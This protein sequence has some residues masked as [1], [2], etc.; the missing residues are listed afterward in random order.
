[1]IIGWLCG[2][3]NLISFANSHITDHIHQVPENTAFFWYCVTGVVVMMMGHVCH[4]YLQ[5]TQAPL[6]EFMG[7][8]ITLTGLVL[9]IFMPLSAVWLFLPQGLLIIVASRKHRLK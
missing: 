5:Q 2:L 3:E 1:M 7:W 6:P 8:Y 4:Y 9:G